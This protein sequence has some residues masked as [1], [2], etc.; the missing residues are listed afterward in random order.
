[1]SKERSEA[2][3]LD[4]FIIQTIKKNRPRTVEQLVEL[5]QADYSLPRKKILECILRLQDQRKIVLEEY[6]SSL[7]LRFKSYIFSAKSEWYWAII[8]I[9]ITTA[10]IVFTVPENVY[11]AM[12]AR[13]L[14]GFIFV[15]LLPGYSL[16]KAF[17]PVKELDN[18]ERIALSIGMSL[19]LVPI[20][21]L[22]LNYTPWGIRTTPVVVSL[23]A[24]TTIFATAAIIRE[25]QTRI[26]ASIET[27]SENL[28][29]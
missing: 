23:L 28:S 18:V 16:I 1:L 12:Y 9:C 15:L 24:L 17:F 10:A 2:R 6:S 13:Y 19:A 26:R 25:Y 29:Y 8:A 27:Q 11:P 21:G 5:V 4:E 22:L 7:P 14:F 3:N 20:T